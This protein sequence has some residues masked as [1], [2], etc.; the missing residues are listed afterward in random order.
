MWKPIREDYFN[1]D[2]IFNATNLDA[3]F[4][5]CRNY[6]DAP[7]AVFMFHSGFV[8]GVTGYR[9]DRAA[10]RNGRLRYRSLRSR[11]PLLLRVGPRQCRPMG[12]SSP[13]S[14]PSSFPST[15]RENFL[16]PAA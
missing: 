16:P 15:R 10:R 13:C 6:L 9:R 12:L 7:H 4:T 8:Q 1:N 3:I 2:G 11:H 5:N 14:R